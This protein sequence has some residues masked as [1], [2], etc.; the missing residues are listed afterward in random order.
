MDRTKRFL[1]VVG[2]LLAA[3]LLLSGCA[4]PAPITAVQ[5]TATVYAPPPT[6]TPPLPPEPT[7]A[8]L[9][10][11]LAAPSQEPVEM[12]SDQSCVDCHTNEET[13][14]AVAKE[15]VVVEDVSEGEG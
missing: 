4:E 7:P 15:E 14:K 13:L 12:V 2:L 1:A 8:A 3:T 11:P 10:F 6:E 9:D 5:P